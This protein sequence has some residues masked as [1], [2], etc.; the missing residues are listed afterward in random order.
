MLAGFGPVEGYSEDIAKF[1]VIG[2]LGTVFPC[3]NW[4]KHFRKK[5]ISD[6]LFRE[7]FP[8]TLSPTT[9]H[10]FFSLLHQKGFLRRIYTQNIDALEVLAG[11]PP[12][13]IIGELRPTSVD[14]CCKWVLSGA[15]S[16]N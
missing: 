13:K 4:I 1:I 12:E 3:L 5:K 15:S 8:E 9:T 16:F 6:R 14:S 2:A 7:I 11:I 10:K